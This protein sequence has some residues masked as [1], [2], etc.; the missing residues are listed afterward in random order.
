MKRYFVTG[1]DTDAGKTLVSSALLQKAQQ[2]GQTTFGLKPVA[3]GCELTD[4]DNGKE[5]QNEDAQ[6][7]RRYSSEQHPY[8]THNPVALR[9]AIA[10]HIAA[11]LENNSLSKASLFEACQPG[12]DATVDFQLVEGA[13]GWLVPLNNTETL[14]DFACELDAEII[15]VVGLRLGCI[16][17]ALLTAHMVQNSGARL[18]G[19]VANSLSENMEAQAGNLAF[20]KQWFTEQSIS[21]LGHTPFIAGIDRTDPEQLQQITDCLTLP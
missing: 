15:L 6:L 19:W 3:A 10:P 4:G 18:I 7:L 14:A 12:L 2:Q 5:W 11:E 16:N 9:A 13:G 20:L 17:H 8:S 1:T 21:F